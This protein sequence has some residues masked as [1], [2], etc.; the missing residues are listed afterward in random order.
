MLL[1]FKQ[2]AQVRTPRRHHVQSPQI[3]RRLAPLFS[4][5]LFHGRILPFDEPW[6]G[7]HPDHE[8]R[9]IPQMRLRAITS[10]ADD[11]W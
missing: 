6:N 3:L 2:P 7:W 1:S 5:R 10:A 9:L 4:A 8:K 11:G